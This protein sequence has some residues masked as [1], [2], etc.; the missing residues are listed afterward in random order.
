MSLDVRLGDGRDIFLADIEGDID[1]TVLAMNVDG[2]DSGDFITVDASA[3]VD[4]GS[5]GALAV[6]LDGGDWSVG[7]DVLTV[8]YAGEMDG[9]LAFTARGRGGPDHLHADV[10]FH[11]GSTGVMAGVLDGGQGDDH[12]FY[13]IHKDCPS[14]TLSIAVALVRGGMGDD[15]YDLTSNVQRRSG[16]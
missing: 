16:V 11:C 14:D 4:I 3:D 9:L 13:H 10:A 7:R 8:N 2:G 15:S 5:L 1:N 6:T 12:L